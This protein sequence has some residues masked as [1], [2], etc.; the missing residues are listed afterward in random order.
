MFVEL[1]L[2]FPSVLLP[3][4]FPFTASSASLVIFTLSNRLE[5]PFDPSGSVA[6]ACSDL[7]LA[8]LS[9][10]LCETSL[11]SFPLFC[12]LFRLSRRECFSLRL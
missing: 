6:A 2:P 12:F 7:E 1:V 8:L 10:V 4:L 9:V 3:P 11:L 5:R